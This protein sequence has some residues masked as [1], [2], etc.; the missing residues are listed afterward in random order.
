M[1]ILKYYTVISF[2][3]MQYWDNNQDFENASCSSSMKWNLI[4]LSVLLLKENST[5]VCTATKILRYVNAS[6][7]KLPLDAT[8]NFPV[9]I[10][11]NPQFTSKA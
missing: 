6:G 7:P 4:Y 8:C 9:L 5:T 1:I 11:D 3:V 10:V 2:Q